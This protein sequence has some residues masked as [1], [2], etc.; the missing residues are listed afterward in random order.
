[1]ASLTSAQAGIDINQTSR[2]VS[3]NPSPC[4]TKSVL[5]VLVNVRVNV[6]NLIHHLSVD[7]GRFSI[8]SV[9]SSGKI[10]KHLI[11]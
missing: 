1:M 11:H 10:R 8:K 3:E 5:K 6:L 9:T 2:C 4:A 7:I